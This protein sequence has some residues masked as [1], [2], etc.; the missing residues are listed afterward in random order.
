MKIL[1][2]SGAKIESILVDGVNV[3]RKT[4]TGDESKRLISQIEKQA[5]FIPD[6]KI[7]TPSVLSVIHTDQMCEVSME[8]I[9]GLDFV[10]FT[11]QS[12]ICEF[13]SKI[14][15]LIS[16]VEEEIKRSQIQK[17][18]KDKWIKKLDSLERLSLERGIEKSKVDKIVNFI[19][20]SIPEKILIG[21]CHGDLTFSNI[22][23]ERNGTLC[24]FDFLDP[25]I[26][27]PYED[28]SKLL[29]DA[30]FFWTLKKYKG[31]CDKTRVK[32]M[33]TYAKKMILKEL[34]DKID[35]SILSMFQVMT[36]FRIIPYTLEDSI[37]E[38]LVDSMIGKID[39]IDPALWR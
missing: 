33:W 14:S 27:T 22:I 1:G 37:I 25:P 19:K 4:C 12:D 39:E 7:R 9:N 36:L 31:S 21:N 5:R 29:Q 3:I 34:G 32:I 13:E 2:N 26:E 24:V 6:P 8:F 20:R 35:L 17:F 28:I 11:S 15:I 16:R 23:V 38:Y 10:T 30:E 18:P